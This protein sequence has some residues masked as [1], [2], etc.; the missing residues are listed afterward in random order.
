MAEIKHIHQVEWM[1]TQCGTRMIKSE[2]AG[3]P[4]PGHCPRREGKPHKWVKNRVR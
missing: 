1:C 3:R 4:Q 2:L